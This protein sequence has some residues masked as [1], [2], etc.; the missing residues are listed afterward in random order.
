MLGR[1]PS[2]LLA[3]LMLTAGSGKVVVMKHCV[4]KSSACVLYISD[5]RR[6][7]LEAVDRKFCEF[8]HHFSGGLLE[9]RLVKLA[10]K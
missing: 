10:V 8:D 6:W 5:S 1:V 7:Q 9:S 3:H 2:T 4:I